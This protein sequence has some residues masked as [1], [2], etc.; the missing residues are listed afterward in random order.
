[1][2]LL[3]IMQGVSLQGEIQNYLDFERSDGT[4]FQLPVPEESV[5]LLLSEIYGTKPEA[6]VEHVE[7]HGDR[8][9]TDDPGGSDLPDGATT[10][11]GD[12]TEE[13]PYVREETFTPQ[14]ESEVPSL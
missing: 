11:G 12:E 4:K 9:P 2:K 7:D 3:G 13:E 14:S 8:E 5:K 6:S 1:M 10:F